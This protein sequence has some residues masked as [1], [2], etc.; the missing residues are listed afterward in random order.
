MSPVPRRILIA[1]CGDLG[2]R[3]GRVLAARGD[4]VFGLRRRVEGLPAYIRPVP[5]DL[6]QRSSLRALPGDLDAA[7]VVLTPSRRDESG[8]REA[9]LDAPANLLDALGAP[10]PRMAFVSSTAV[11]G[12]DDGGWVEEDT[13]PAPVGFNGR[14]LWQAEQ[15]LAERVPGLWRLRLAGI[16]GPGR[17]WMLRRA[18]EATRCRPRWTNRIHV[19]DAARAIGFA[20]DAE[21]PGSACIVSDG[22]PVREDELLGWLAQR[23]QRPAPVLEPG[24]EGGRRLRPRRLPALGFAL[25][26]PDWQEGYAAL[27]QGDERPAI[28]P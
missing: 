9:F 19:E 7:V 28:V 27:L 25:R 11:Y 24:P 15:A 8:Y 17:T 10:P 26:W 12:G 16:Y 14:V 21:A 5:A 23:L 3:L 18:A 2:Q 4:T 6:L 13:P 20:L 22:R 1:G